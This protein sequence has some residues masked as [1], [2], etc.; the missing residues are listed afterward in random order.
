MVANLLIAAA[1]VPGGGYVS[2]AKVVVALIILLIWARLMSWV[3]VDAPAAHLPRF[4]V[5][6]I[7]MGGLILAFAIFFWVPSFW[8]AIPLLLVCAGAEAGYYLNMRKK[9]VGLN[10]LRRQFDNWINGFRGKKKDDRGAGEVVLIARNN[11]PVP[12]PDVGT[13]ERISYDGVQLAL[14]EPLKKNAEQIDIDG[15]HQSGTTIK[16]MVDGM[17]YAGKALEGGSGAAAIDLIKGLAAINI[18]EKRKPQSGKMKLTLGGVKHELKVQTAGSTAGEYVRMMVDPKNRHNYPLDKLGFSESQ[19]EK[20]RSSIKENKGVVLLSTPKGMGL[21][22]LQYGILR[23]HDAFI[24]HLQ[25][26]ERD[27]EEDLEGITQNKLAANAKPDEEY[28]M[29]DWVISQEPDAILINKLEDPRSAIALI[30]HSKNHKRVY[31]SMRAASTFEALAQWRKLVGDDTLAVDGLEMVINGRVLRKL[32]N[33]CKVAVA[34]DP[35]ML[36]KLGMNPEKVTQLFQARTQPQRDPKGNPI[37]CTFC[38]DLRFLGRTGV[39]EIMIID[40]EMRQAV[41]AGKP[42]EPIFR[43]QRSRFLQEEALALVEAGDTSVQEVKRILKPDA[44][45][46]AAVPEGTAP[47]SA[48]PPAAAAGAPRRTTSS[49]APVRKSG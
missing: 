12:V 10:D 31:V 14:T 2:I 42:V 49:A 24:Q 34:P 39:F 4:N 44:A 43:K 16:Y 6:M 13:P 33:N 45:A 25:T 20:V 27:P 18:E 29:V 35:P 21:T 9:V 40:D 19:L 22:S 15:R 17:S 26:I 28:K 32:C 8:L 30:N 38:N 36:R 48:A 3:D 41:A 11:H 47:P 1:P 46:A 5:N 7:N 23:G 37:P